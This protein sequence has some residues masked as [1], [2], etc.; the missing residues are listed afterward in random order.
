MQRHHSRVRGTHPH[1]INICPTRS[2]IPSTSLGDNT[3]AVAAAL[4]DVE[5][6]LE[7]KVE[8]DDDLSDPN[9]PDT[10]PKPEPNPPPPKL[11]DLDDILA[12]LP[13]ATLPNPDA[14][15]NRS[16]LLTA[17]ATVPK[18]T[19]AV[20][21]PNVGVCVPNA[22]ADVGM[23]ADD[24]DENPESSG[25]S[26][27]EDVGARL[28]EANIPSPDV[29]GVS[30]LFFPATAAD[31]LGERL[32]LTIFL[33]CNTSSDA[34]SNGSL[35]FPPSSLTSPDLTSHS[36]EQS[37]SSPSGWSSLFS[38]MFDRRFFEEGCCWWW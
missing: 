19:P 13:L 33:F 10:V 11:D 24:D 12:S 14:K 25:A 20:I 5:P 22:N 34:R 21:D 3:F 9:P 26:T 27:D 16:P 36:S 8:D 28:T 18:P 30:P 31:H 17:A 6:K 15:P 37:P 38:W 35:R 32:A 29:A 23:L 1:H 2:P 4:L 7:P